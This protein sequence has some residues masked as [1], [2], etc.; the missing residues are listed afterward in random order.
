[1]DILVGI[2]LNFMETIYSIR[3][4]MFQEVN[5]PLVDGRLGI[6]ASHGCVRLAL[7]N[8]KWIYDNIPVGTKVVIY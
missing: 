7:T 4:Y 8:A 3:F 1:M 2:I 5:Q 6:N